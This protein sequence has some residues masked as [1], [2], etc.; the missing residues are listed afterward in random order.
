MIFFF[1]TVYKYTRASHYNK[2]L[3]V[4]CNISDFYPPPPSLFLPKNEKGVIKSWLVRCFWLNAAQQRSKSAALCGLGGAGAE[5]LITWEFAKTS[6]LLLLRFRTFVSSYMYMWPQF[7]PSRATSLRCTIQNVYSRG[8]ERIFLKRLIFYL[9]ITRKE[10]P[11]ILVK[12]RKT[13]CTNR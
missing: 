10:K 1:C 7:C 11:Q 9:I 2:T 12:K 3:I 5:V 13:K 8:I 6:L 4:P